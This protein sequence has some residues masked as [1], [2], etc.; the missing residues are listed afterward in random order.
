[1]TYLEIE[2]KG[3]LYLKNATKYQNDNI[4][5]FAVLIK[6]KKTCKEF[7]FIKCVIDTFF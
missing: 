6:K 5:I 2:K 3:T 4:C 1:M 7:S